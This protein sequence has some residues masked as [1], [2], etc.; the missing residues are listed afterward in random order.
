MF[1]ILSASLKRRKL[2]LFLSMLLLVAGIYS[3]VTIPKQEMPDL[4]VPMAVVQV[5]SPGV[6][7]SEMEEIS[8]SVEA[9]LE[10]YEEVDYYVTITLDNVMIGQVYFDFSVDDTAIVSSKIEDDILNLD[11]GGRIDS[12]SVRTDFNTPHVVYAFTG[13]DIP[14]LEDVAREYRELVLE[15]DQVHKASIRSSL[16]TYVDVVI[17]QDVLSD[18][19]LTDVYG[20]IYANSQSIPLGTIDGKTLQI[21]GSFSSVEDLK[22][23]NVTFVENPYTGELIP[24]TLE[25]FASINFDEYDGKEYYYNGERTVFLE[26]YFD[27]DI[28]FSLL[29]KKLEDVKTDFE[30]D[31]S[32][33]EMSYIPDYVD[34]Q[35]N[36]AMT[37]LL[38]CIVIVMIVVLIGLGLRNSI[39]IAI[40]IPIIV[41]GTIFAIDL[42]GYELQRVSIAGIVISI[43]I[44][45]DN[46]IVISDAIQYYLD[47]GVDVLTA[48]K[49]AIKDNSIAVLSS[50]L[51][52]VA[53]FIP[54]TMLPGLAG[55]MAK[56]L[57]VT[58][59]IAISLSYAF[60]V[61]VTPVIASYI[62]K[63][64][65]PKKIKTNRLIKV[66]MEKVLN[67]PKWVVYFSFIALLV[68]S[69]FVI[70]NQPIDIFPAD[71]K[72]E[73]YIDFKA[74]D[75]SMESSK[76]LANKIAIE[77]DSFSEIDDYYYSIGGGLPA[78]SG[79]TKPVNEV[80][81]EGRFYIHTNLDFSELEEFVP[82]VS[83]RLNNFD[84]TVQ[85]NRIALGIASAPVEISVV[86]NDQLYLSRVSDYLEDFLRESDDVMDYNIV[87]TSYY[88]TY[89]LDIDREL[90]AS[91]NIQLVEL[92]NFIYTNLNGLKLN[93]FQ[94]KGE[95][96]DI[97][98]HSEIS[99]FDELLRLEVKGIVLDDLIDIYIDDS[100]EA[101]YK[102]NG[103]YQVILEAHPVS[104]NALE[105]ERDIKE[106]LNQYNV[107]IVI[108]G[109]SELA[110]TIFGDLGQAAVIAVVL[111]YLVMFIQFNSFS[112]PIIVFFTIPL[113]LIGSFVMMLIFDTPISLTSLLGIVS[114]IG[115][116]VNTGILLVEYI[117]KAMED[118]LSKKDACVESVRRRFR[119]IMLASTTTV[120]GLIPLMLNGGEFFR[121]LAIVFMGGIISTTGLTLFVVPSL[122]MIFVSEKH[123]N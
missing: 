35:I 2:V 49:R 82:L 57:P 79:T 123:L 111:I 1:K 113:S 24:L 64:R 112:Q 18:L 75:P 109:D 50:T 25:E 87:Q 48:A 101:I 61:L 122:Y 90:L 23:L 118:G 30:S 14:V 102:Y 20:L 27:E 105:L 76:E 9:V 96:I 98:I 63:P 81:D 21:D 115:V 54:L 12:V 65:N 43:G 106:F 72:S 6:S 117:N 60:A 4:I 15:L 104:D 7:A 31:V 39:A 51:T 114:L 36:Q 3:Y 74:T 53:A 33:T 17:N 103:D 62:F 80:V 100:Y 11:L 88:E 26:V 32:I 40:T 108:G 78:F 59:M 29:G 97:F 52:T 45:V 120:L 91:S 107:D 70:R 94:Y 68:S 16:N 5:V 28:D 89:R 42:I 85:V 41:F 110:N 37:S 56:S 86:S 92:Q 69:F 34:Y 95:M 44:L 19:S 77:L 84:G 46:S 13:D 121:P 47:R 67:Y 38:L 66:V 99:T 71:E 22:S 83:S 58:V 119:P 8:D 93:A 10:E 55:Q 116:V 73:F